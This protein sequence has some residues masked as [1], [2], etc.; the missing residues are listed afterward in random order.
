MPNTDFI[1]TI[2]KKEA[3]QDIEKINALLDVMYEKFIKTALA[4]NTLSDSLGKA[5]GLKEANEWTKK[6]ITEEEELL[7]ISHQ[8]EAA[9]IKR[10]AAESK[11]AQ[12]LAKEKVLLQQ[13]NKENANAAKIALTQ[14]GGIARMEAI[15]V[16]LRASQRNLNLE[17][18]EGRKKSEQYIKAIDN[19]NNKIK[20]SSDAAKRQSLNVGNY[21]GSAKIIVDALTKV[22]DK[23]SEL[24]IKQKGLQELGQRNP[25]GFRTQGG[26]EQLNTINAQ[27]KSAEEAAKGLR[28][29]VDQP[30]FLNVADKFANTNRE[31]VFFRNQ[32]NQLKASGAGA[33]VIQE[34]TE[35]L[36][37]LTDELG[38]TKEEIKALSSDTRS[39]DLFA[40]SV[41]FAADAFQTFAGAAQLAGASEEDA[42]KATA[43][44]VA[45]QSVA[46]GVKGIATELTTKGTAA[47]KVYAFTQGLVATAFDKSAASAKRFYAALGVIGLIITVIGGIALAMGQLNKKLSEGEQRQKAFNDVV[48]ESAGDFAKA[49]VEIAKMGI[50]FDLA[51]Q[52]VL[53]K[54]TVLKKYNETIGKTIGQAEDLTE[55]EKLY[56]EN[57][58]AYIEVMFAKAKA[59]AAFALANKAA[60]ESVKNENATTEELLTTFDKIVGFFKSGGGPGGIF[61][62]AQSDFTRGEENRA[63]NAIKLQE[64]FNGLLNIGTKELKAAEE[65]SKKRGFT[66]EEELKKQEEARKKAEEA[67]KKAAEKQRKIDEDL[68]KFIKKL[69]EDE[70]K[71]KIDL[72]NGYN[73]Q[74]ADNL[75]RIADNEKLSLNERLLANTAYFKAQEE[76]INSRAKQEQDALLASAKAEAENI[77]GRKLDPK[78]DGGLILQI[79]RATA[80][81]RLAI[82]QKAENEIIKIRQEG[83]DKQ[84]DLVLK[85]VDKQLT[86]LHNSTAKQINAIDIAEQEKLL[87]LERKFSAGKIKQKD[88][89]KAKLDIQN[90]FLEQRLQLEL[91]AAEQFL[92][93]QKAAGLDTINAEKQIADIKLALAKS[94]TDQL[95]DQNK[96]QF[97]NDKEFKEKRKDLLMQLRDEVANA[98]F[99][100]IDGSLKKQKNALEQEKNIIEERKQR[101]LNRIN[102]LQE[103]EE[104]KAARVQILEAQTDNQKRLIEQRQKQIAIKQA[105]VEKARAA[106]DIGINTAVA[107]TKVMPNPFLIAL[108]SAIGLLQLGAVL[109][110]PIPQYYTGTEDSQG[111][112]AWLGERGKEL[113]ITPQGQAYETPG[114]ATLADIPAHS[115]VIKHDEYMEMLKGEK[116]NSTMRVNR[117]G[118]LEILSGQLKLNQ[119]SNNEIIHELKELNKKPDAVFKI[120]DYGIENYRKHGASWTEYLNRK[121]RFRK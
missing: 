88:Y 58:D 84:S 66:N 17:T 11:L 71:A 95:A 119:L 4:A 47:N 74:V 96:K 94:T 19:L 101:E 91:A 68:R 20:E 64:K 108:V 114:T 82:Q 98:V 6:L 89:E 86:L 52:G 30:Q 103:S 31:I 110:K 13:V 65:E 121:V 100:F 115:K 5:N 61:R 42:A 77:L 106:F 14:A 107:I 26:Q 117:N 16:K 1:D 50:E 113:L 56:L 18:E 38:D 80:N 33:E 12:E 28:N 9:K 78:K 109:S 79:E 10:S 46:N 44:L 90:D 2:V 29:V 7:R 92:A 21:Q 41:T 69:N 8:I 99:S 51:K 102:L 81:Q 120:T 105:Q 63:D 15:V 118:E 37:K 59:A 112:L 57:K 104:Q 116:I 23:I 43:Q 32:L 39:F 73:Q 34:L 97:D 54:E 49:K 60:E 35:H 27:L 53:D 40:G 45:V 72:L 111:G 70:G 3:Y 87:A 55:A 67:A 22:E 36:A 75:Q 62:K 25:I 93:I 85:E 76:L 83:L 48:K 24:T